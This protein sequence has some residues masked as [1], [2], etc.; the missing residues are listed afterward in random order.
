M[1]KK[2]IGNVRMVSLNCPNCGAGLDADIDNLQAFCPFCGNKLMIDVGQMDDILKEKEKTRQKG[3][4]YQR[5]ISAIKMI[6]EYKKEKDERD[7]KAALF[8]A[9]GIFLFVLIVCAVGLY[10][11]R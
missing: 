2:G 1:A 11:S 7:T 3:L 8:A 4:K 9:F 5:D 10:L 6:G